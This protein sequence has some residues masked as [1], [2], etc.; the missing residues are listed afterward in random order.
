M[1]DAAVR[2]I[3]RAREGEPF[4]DLVDL[5]TRARI[6]EEQARAIASFFVIR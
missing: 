2:R 4:R 6:N 1:I 3:L 5:Q